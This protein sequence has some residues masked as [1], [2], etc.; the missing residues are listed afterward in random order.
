MKTQKMRLSFLVTSLL[1]LLI[2]ILS[3]IFIQKAEVITP[4]DRITT[5]AAIIV[6]A[7]EKYF[8]KY[9]K[10]PD[11]LG[12]LFLSKDLF[13]KFPAILIP[14]GNGQKVTVRISYKDEQLIFIV[15]VTNNDG[16]LIDTSHWERQTKEK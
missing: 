7:I 6:R 16:E 1:I 4:K 9:N 5:N 10:L 3:V 15:I 8:R 11:N 12:Q 13:G 14:Q 2:S